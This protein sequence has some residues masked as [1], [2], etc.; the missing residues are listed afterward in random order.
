MDSPETKPSIFS[1]RIF[2]KGFKDIQREKRIAFSANAAGI[3]KESHLK[4]Q[5]SNF[6]SHHVQKLTANE[7]EKVSVKSKTTKFLEE[8]IGVN[9]LKILFVY[10]FL[11]VLVFFAAQAFP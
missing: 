4:E 3:P 7:S 11:S 10:L 1:Q 9:L 2:D 8:N 6:V 5:S